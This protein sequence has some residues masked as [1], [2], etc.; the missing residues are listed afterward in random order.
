MHMQ[1]NQHKGTKGQRD[2]V[3]LGLAALCSF[4]PLFLWAKKLNPPRIAS[5]PLAVLVT[6]CL[7]AAAHAQ[8]GRKPPQ[9]PKKPATE[10]P[11]A[12][13]ETKEVVVP[14]SAY[15]AEGNLVSDLTSKDVLV[16]EDGEARPV[17][18]LKHEPANIALVLDLNNEIGTFKNASHMSW[19]QLEE[20]KKQSKTRAQEPMWKD[21]SKYQV[22]ARPATRE[23]ADNFVARISPADSLAI[24]QYSD[25]VQLI[26]DWTSEREQAL[27]AL[28]SKYRIGLKGRFYDALKLAAEKLEERTTGRRLLVVISDGMDS[29]SRANRQ[30]AFAAI[31]RAQA[32]VFVISWAGVLSGEVEAAIVRT[33]Q[34]RKPGIEIMGGV[35]KRLVEL[36]RYLLTLEGTTAQLRELAETTGGELLLPPSYE[37]LVASPQRLAQE[38]GAQYSLAFI[39]ETK[40]SLDNTRSINVVAARP[41]LTVR[42]RRSYWVGD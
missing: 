5:L 14:L 9:D 22:V 23:F 42:S 29:A 4:V 3:A 13:I 39:T 31:V 26:Q 21:G 36:R 19:A 27:F 25:R 15:D 1:S 33:S 18:Y 16:L 20:E 24:I 2:K 37:A 40:P 35:G 8:S 10:K 41:G 11:V 34:Q 7:L 28:R 30:Q 38:I 32:T 6:L 17:S 12:R